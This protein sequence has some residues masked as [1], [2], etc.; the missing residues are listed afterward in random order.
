MSSA[1]EQHSASDKWRFPALQVTLPDW[2]AKVIP[3]P[4]HRYATTEERMELAIELSRLN[5]EYG[6]GPFGAAVFDS[7]VNTLVAP[8]VNT[9]VASRWSGA[10]AEM[11]ALAIA[12][13]VAKTHDLGATDSTHYELV[14]S[15]APCSMC[16]GATPW[17]GVK[18]LVCAAREEDARAIGFDEGPKPASWVEALETRGIE[19]VLDIQRERAQ[20]VLQLYAAQGGLIYNGRSGA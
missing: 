4:D 7:Q 1:S 8:G 10:H 14:T 17:S 18:R 13:Q 11:V 12:Q 20:G 19:V 16:F 15:C 9:V 2:V 5:I 3:P 6:G